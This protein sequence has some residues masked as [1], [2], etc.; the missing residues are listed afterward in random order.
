MRAQVQLAVR[1]S[2]IEA[3]LR[4][5]LANGVLARVAPLLGARRLDA[6]LEAARVGRAVEQHLAHFD[7]LRF[8]CFERR[9]RQRG[10][11]RCGEPAQDLGRRWTHGDEL[12]DAA[13]QLGRKQLGMNRHEQH[14]DQRFRQQAVRNLPLGRHQMVCFV[15]D[16]PVR[17][18]VARA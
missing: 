17:A 15:H 4:R 1:A 3:P 16:D 18:T 12:R 5:Q 7:A 2:K 8:R 9:G 6:H 10:A 11:A 14:V 13:V